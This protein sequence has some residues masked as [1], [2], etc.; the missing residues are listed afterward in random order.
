MNQVVFYFSYNFEEKTYKAPHELEDSFVSENEERR[1][2]FGVEDG[3]TMNAV[4]TQQT[5]CFQ[6]TKIFQL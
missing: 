4:V 3:E 6:Q 5:S 2:I 1:W